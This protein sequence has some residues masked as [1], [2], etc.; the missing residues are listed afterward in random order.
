MISEKKTNTHTSHVP[1]A[2]RDIGVAA[3]F[4]WLKSPTK[5]L[6]PGHRFRKPRFF[7][8]E[9]V[10]FIRL[11]DVFADFT[12]LKTVGFLFASTTSCLFHNIFHGLIETT[13]LVSIFSVRLLQTCFKPPKVGQTYLEKTSRGYQPGDSSRDPLIP[14]NRWSFNHPKKVTF[15]ELPGIF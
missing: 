11:Q 10:V 15:A 9:N 3:S 4:H 8:T 6:V 7:N 12:L 14:S 1:K 2:S 13:K 5:H